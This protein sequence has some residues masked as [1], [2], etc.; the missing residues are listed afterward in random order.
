MHF[1]PLYESMYFPFPAKTSLNEISSM[2]DN[3][4]FVAAFVPYDEMKIV[5]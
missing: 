4:T 3:S 1:T 5:L 2:H